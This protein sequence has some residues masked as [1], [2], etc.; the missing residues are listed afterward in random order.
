M[1]LSINPNTIQKAYGELERE[2][3]IYSVK[4]R[5]NL[6]SSNKELVEEKKKDILIR[7]KKLVD[8]GKAIGLTK[9]EIIS[10]LKWKEEKE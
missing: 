6:V 9:E 2:G 5:G 10:F 7:I 4:G 3:F 1:E 8:D